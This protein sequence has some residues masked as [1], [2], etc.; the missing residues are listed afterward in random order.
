MEVMLSSE[1]R[2]QIKSVDDP[3]QA[4][5]LSKS[6]IANKLAEKTWK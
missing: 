6:G 3:V 5:E 2:N 1:K 4:A